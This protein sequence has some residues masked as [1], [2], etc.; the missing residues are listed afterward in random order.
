[1][2]A[3]VT[4]PAPVPSS[5]RL[6]P[7]TLRSGDGD[8]AKIPTGKREPV[9][10][11]RFALAEHDLDDGFDALEEPASFEAAAGNLAL[12]V[13]FLEGYSYAQVYAP[14]DRNFICFE[15][16]TAPTNALVSGNRLALVV[17]GQQYRAAFRVS[18][19][20]GGELDDN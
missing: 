16:M 11:R 2:S 7:V 8:E 19:S 14:V 18:I 15:P 1:M 4:H 6:D 3:L 20:R 9:C 17:P 5:E 13:E 12:K 10:R